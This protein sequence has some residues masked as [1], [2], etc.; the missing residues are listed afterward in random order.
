MGLLSHA[1]TRDANEPE[2]VD[3]LLAAGASVD[4]VDTPCDLIV[5][6]FGEN[7]EPVTTLMEVKLPLGPQGGD[8]H[9]RLTPTEMEF[10]GR[11]KGVIVVVR[12]P[13]DALRAIG[14][15]PSAIFSKACQ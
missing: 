1:N 6:H 7:G 3:A 4:R 9:S 8:S 10:H 2:I 13:E 14:K 11:H 5:G 12:D 15:R